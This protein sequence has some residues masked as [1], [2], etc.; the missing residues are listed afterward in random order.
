MP[1]KNRRG[2]T[3]IELL[4]GALAGAMLI[5]AMIGGMKLM[6][7]T[8]KSVTLDT[9]SEGDS[10]G[11][12]LHMRRIARL[13]WG[14]KKTP[15]PEFGLECELTPPTDVTT[16]RRKSKFVKMDGNRVA[17]SYWNALKGIWE[18]P[19]TYRGIADL[20][21]CDDEDMGPLGHCSLL[22]KEM[23][24]LHSRDPL[25][26]VKRFFRIGITTAS[27]HPKIFQTAFFLRNPG[28]ME[29]QFRYEA[30]NNAGGMER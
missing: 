14:C 13:A 22:P 27:P 2:L 20:E 9:E 21:L 25:K 4:V 16:D 5:Y 15:K 8:Q 12:L 19:L 11:A 3:L 30:F 17:Y 7:K 1:K 28:P 10:F 6:T 23:N 24:E 29:P 26:K 18:T